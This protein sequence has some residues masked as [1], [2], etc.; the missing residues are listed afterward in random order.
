MTRIVRWS[1]LVAATLMVGAC[2]VAEQPNEVAGQRQTL[3]IP[4]ADYPLMSTLN[5]FPV[6]AGMA[7]VSSD[8]AAVTVT[9]TA[10]PGFVI[11]YTSICA[12]FGAVTSTDPWQC[13][14][15]QNFGLSSTAT[16]STVVIPFEAIGEPACGDALMM[17]IMAKFLHVQTQSLHFTGVG[18]QYQ[19]V[20]YTFLCDEEPD[21][22]TDYGCTLTQGFW[23]NHPEAWPVDELTL[24]NRTYTK[25]ELLVI[26]K[27]PT[28]GDASLILG[29]QLIAAMLNVAAGAGGTDAFM[30]D[31]AAAQAWMSANADAD[32][33]LPYRT[34]NR[35]AGALASANAKMLGAMLD[36]YNNGEYGPVHCEDGPIVVDESMNH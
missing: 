3:S 14:Y 36:A 20:A 18:G 2:A 9:F 12:T 19:F 21:A 27:T 24:G 25:A 6:Q 15:V 8:D 34:S 17:Q 30:D 10:S 33:K 1:F 11:V 28:R 29:H 22:G 35:G 26:L 4:A 5:G 31:L 23:K 7:T 16:T 32:G 13:P